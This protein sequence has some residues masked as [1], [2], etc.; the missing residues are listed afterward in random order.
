MV[1]VASHFNIEYGGRRHLQMCDKSSLKI[2]DAL[3]P[4]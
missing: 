4:R 3:L 2:V 1:N